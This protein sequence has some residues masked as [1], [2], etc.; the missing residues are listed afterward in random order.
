MDPRLE[1]QRLEDLRQEA[2]EER[3]PLETAR[4]RA[5]RARRALALGQGP[6]RAR[7]ERARR[8]ARRGRD[9]RDP[10]GAKI[11]KSRRARTL[12]A[13]LDRTSGSFR[14]NTFCSF[15]GFVS[16]KCSCSFLGFVPPKCRFDSRP[17]SPANAGDPV[18]TNL[19]EYWMPRIR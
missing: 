17:S 8:S 7:D 15:L 13:S 5:R 9:C 19:I 18:I 14:Q 11:E 12:K 6:R 16:P 3:R 1:A 4:C 10:R 2:G